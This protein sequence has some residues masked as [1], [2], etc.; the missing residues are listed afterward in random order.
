L[1]VSG[2]V[3][4]IYGSLGVKRLIRWANF[5]LFQIE[6]ISLWASEWTVPPVTLT[7]KVFVK[8][9]YP[10]VRP[11][12]SLHNMSVFY[13]KLLATCPNL[14][15]RS[16]YF[17]PSVTVYSINLLL[18]HIWRLSPWLA[19]CRHALVTMG[20]RINSTSIPTKVL[21]LFCTGTKSIIF[22]HT[23]NNTNNKMWNKK[24]EE[25]YVST[26]RTQSYMK[27]KTDE[28]IKE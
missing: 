9:M 26:E 8:T 13:S 24:Y 21:Y 27:H 3:R 25:P 15:W 18:L 5:S 10:S 14:V 22:K 12:E 11:C 20:F 19:I 17:Q 28:V 2:A 7:Y 23:S 1:E 16:T 4:P 6:L